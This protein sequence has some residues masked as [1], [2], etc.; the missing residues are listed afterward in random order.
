MHL[1]IL[2]RGWTVIARDETVRF[3]YRKLDAS[4][5]IVFWFWHNRIQVYR[6]VTIL[7]LVAIKEGV[8]SRR[9]AGLASICE[10]YD[11]PSCM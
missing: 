3:A 5:M 8:V 1:T 4:L 11:L 10:V 6:D 7:V 9:S 2:K